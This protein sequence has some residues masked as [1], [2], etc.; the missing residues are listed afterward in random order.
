MLSCVRL[1]ANPRTVACQAPLSLEFF[2]QE[3]WNRL[4]F[5]LPGDLPDPGV[6]PPS[7]AFPALAGRLFMS[8]PP[9]KSLHKGTNPIF[10]GSTLMT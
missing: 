8:E 7:L 3:Y 10:E 2:K 4:P 5:P 1:F 6:K 9:G